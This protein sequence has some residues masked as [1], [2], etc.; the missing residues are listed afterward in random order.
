MTEEMILNI[1]QQ[2]KNDFPSVKIIVLTGGECFLLGDLLY[3]AIQLFSEAGL[4]VR[5]VTNAFWA[6]S[7][8]KAYGIIQ[9]LKSIGLSE[10]NVSTGDEHLHWVPF[11]NIV[12]AV[13]AAVR[14]DMPIVVNIET[15]DSKKFTCQSLYQDYR[16]KKYINKPN[17]QLLN[18]HW[19]SSEKN[20]NSYQP[21]NNR[22]LIHDNTGRCSSI[23]KTI[24]ISPTG[25]ILGCCGLT[26]Q[27][28]KSLQLGNITIQS[29]HTILENSFQDFI[30][31]WIFTEGPYRILKFCKSQD[32]SLPSIDENLHICEY[33]EMLYTSSAFLN[34]IHKHYKK[35][36]SD[37]LTKYSILTIKK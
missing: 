8:R 20:K 7:F 25:Q 10:I 12:F 24:S 29:L 16:M 15:S 36:L 34:A 31:I 1:I 37:V 35:R 19:I 4:Y 28:H 32:P 17:V 21:I 22:S 13:A 26:S 30:K 2:L 11:D 14:N 18:G 6:N 5:I 9:R 27:N 23:F 3:K 33:C